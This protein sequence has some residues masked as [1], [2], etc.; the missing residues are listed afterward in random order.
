MIK[1]YK[2]AA[3]DITGPLQVWPMVYRGDSTLKEEDEEKK[4][5]KIYNQTKNNQTIRQT[6]GSKTETTLILCGY[7]RELANNCTVLHSSVLYCIKR[8]G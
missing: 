4:N 2:Q 8:G 5:E 1:D 3:A 6:D 7:S